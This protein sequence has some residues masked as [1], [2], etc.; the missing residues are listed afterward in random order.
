[1]KLLRLLITVALAFLTACTATIE[2][3]HLSSDLK[4]PIS[5]IAVVYVGAPPAE[6]DVRN[7]LGMLLFS[8]INALFV[9][10]RA[11]L[12]QD[13]RAL[14]EHVLSALPAELQKAGVQGEH[15]MHYLQHKPRSK[16]ELEK[17]IGKPAVEGSVL[18]IQPI[19]ARMECERACFV[20]TL[21]AVL[22]QDH[23]NSP[24]KWAASIVAPPKASKFSD[25]SKPGQSVAAVLVEKL[26]EDKVL[27]SM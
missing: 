22:Y 9:S 25:F 10:D 24:G 7:S 14:G 2:R 26:K 20:F 3:N 12:I 17:L 18:L 21:D 8:P 15:S 27:K 16:A 13:A 6:K 4:L 5:K 1:M 23:L 11:T 19:S